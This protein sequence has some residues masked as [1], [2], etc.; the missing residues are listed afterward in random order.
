MIRILQSVF[1][2]VG[3]A[4]AQPRIGPCSVFPANN[5]WNVP[6]DELPVAADS[7]TLVNTIGPARRVHADFGSGLWEDAP[8][9]IPFVTVAGNQTKYHASFEYT[10]E[11]DAGPYAVPLTAPIEGAAR[12]AGIVMRSQSI[13]KTASSMSYT[14]PSHM[15][16]PGRPD[17]ARSSISNRHCYV[18]QVGPRRMPP[19]CRS[20]PD[21]SGTTRSRPARF[22][23]QSG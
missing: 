10:G 23:T 20:S 8:I 2:A 7:A 17:L 16:R 6:V 13:R 22:G 11:S 3:V 4:A 9:G 21:W 12:A 15:L 5:I 19:V 18:R 1:L 14:V